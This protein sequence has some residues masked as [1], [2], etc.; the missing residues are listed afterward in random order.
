MFL[1]VVL[2]EIKIC[3]FVKYP[4]VSIVL[5]AS[6]FIIKKEA[7]EGYTGVF[8]FKY[9]I[10]THLHTLQS[11]PFSMGLK[12]FHHAVTKNG[13]RKTTLGFRL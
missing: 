11:L 1:T 2:H 8:F 4:L 7:P 9:M 5:G 12:L 6:L 3:R 10:T 13:Q